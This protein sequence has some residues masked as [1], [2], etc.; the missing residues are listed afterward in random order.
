MLLSQKVKCLVLSRCPHSDPLYVWQEAK[1]L[2]KSQFIHSM[3]NETQGIDK[4]ILSLHKYQ[5]EIV[6]TNFLENFASISSIIYFKT[7]EARVIFFCLRG[8]LIER[9]SVFVQRRRIN[10]RNI[11]RYFCKV[12]PHRYMLFLI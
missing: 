3:S 1:N 9:V 5:S 10:R 2:I 12:T 11:K 7:L 4:A 6:M 8:Q